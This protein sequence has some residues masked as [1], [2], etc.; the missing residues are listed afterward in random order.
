M[1]DEAIAALRARATQARRLSTTIN[2]PRSIEALRQMAQDLETEAATLEASER[3]LR[4]SD[5]E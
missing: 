4:K 5:D 3:A 2:D 1:T